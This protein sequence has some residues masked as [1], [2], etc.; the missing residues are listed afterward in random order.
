MLPSTVERLAA[1][2]PERGTARPDA[3]KMQAARPRPFGRKEEP[4]A[5]LPARNT[6]FTSP[7]S[8]ELRA[9][10]E[11]T[12]HFIGWRPVIQGKNTA[13]LRPWLIFLG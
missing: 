8:D 2:R 5:V 10:H 1:A 6:S 3:A 7:P 9:G 11:L 13:N 4:D 12:V